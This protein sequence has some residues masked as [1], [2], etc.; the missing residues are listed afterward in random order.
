MGKLTLPCTGAHFLGGAIVSR[1]GS[2]ASPYETPPGTGFMAAF[3]PLSS[4]GFAWQ[5]SCECSIIS[6]TPAALGAWGSSITHLS[7]AMPGALIRAGGE[8]GEAG[9]DFMQLYGA[10]LTI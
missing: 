3:S 2:G 10:L 8:H 5:M 1:L 4:G 9:S 6:H 7:Q